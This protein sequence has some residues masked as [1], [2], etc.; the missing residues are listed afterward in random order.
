MLDVNISP[1][2]FARLV[3]KSESWT[4]LARLMSKKTIYTS[5]HRMTAMLK[6]KCLKLQLNTSHFIT[7]KRHAIITDDMLRDI[8]RE[9][10]SL[11]Q[12]ILKCKYTKSSDIR[13]RVF[14]RIKSLSIPYTHLKFRNID[15]YPKAKIDLLDDEEFSKLIS[16]SRSWYD[17]ANKSGNRSTFNVFRKSICMKR[18][19]TLGIDTSHFRGQGTKIMNSEVFI[20]NG[21]YGNT[22]LKKRLIENMHWPYECNSCKNIHYV[23]RD[24]VLMWMDKPIVLQL[25]HKNGIN[26]DNRIENLEF[27]CPNCHTQTSTFCGK[28]L[29]RVRALNSWVEENATD[30]SSSL[31]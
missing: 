3:A 19:K 12:V 16:V 17:F 28:N 29:K 9:S 5:N 7:L 8:V 21:K 2:E 30:A 25:D 15:K 1:E 13:K 4:E 6:K 11:N 10:E 27:L 26:T 20:E 22:V 31:P 18:A 23:E 24:G 14:E